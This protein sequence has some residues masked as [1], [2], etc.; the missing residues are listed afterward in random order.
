MK[1]AF[2]GTPEFAA[3][4]LEAILAAGFEVPL[5]LTQPDRPAGRGMQL[6]P[7]P[8]KQVAL[9][10]G[11]PV[12]QPEKLRTP[13]Q[14]APLAAAGCDVLVWWGH[15]AHAEIEDAVV[16]RLQRHVLAGMGLI[17]LHSGHF[18]RLFRRLMGTHCSLQWRVAGERERLWVVE[19]AHPI[20]A[21]LDDCIE[22]AQEEMYGERFDIPAP[23]S[24]VFISWFEGGEVFRSGCCWQ[25]GHG[26]IF[27]FRP[28]HETFPT[29][30]H[31]Q[32]RRVLA[33]AVQWAAP[34][35]ARRPDRCPK[36]EPRERLHTPKD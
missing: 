6:Q 28:G 7:S 15:R 27:Y 29:Y 3:S 36:V 34:N 12:H 25:R 1:V 11:I 31:P 30:H 24:T 16:D 20:A 18:S 33:N 23:D 26:R 5:V 32:I 13:E 21:G 17:V 14:Q 2:A 22:L 10:A 35:S 4:A 9:A 19:P 8:V